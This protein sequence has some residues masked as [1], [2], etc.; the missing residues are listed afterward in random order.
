M[1]LFEIE[2]MVGIGFRI[3]VVEVEWGCQRKAKPK[4]QDTTIM[5]RP[6]FDCKPCKL[7]STAFA[8]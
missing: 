5:V 8:G 2:L 1:F 3:D 7:L 4:T 6:R